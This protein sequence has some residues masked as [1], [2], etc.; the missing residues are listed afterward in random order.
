[1]RLKGHLPNAPNC[2][3]L[4]KRNSWRQ[5]PGTS[6]TR[7]KSIRFSGFN[8]ESRSDLRIGAFD[9]EP[10]AP[11]NKVQPSLEDIKLAEGNLAD[12]ADRVSSKSTEYTQAVTKLRGMR[13]NLMRQNGPENQARVKARQRL[14][15]MVDRF[16]IDDKRDEDWI[17][18][19]LAPIR[20]NLRT[21]DPKQL[22]SYLDNLERLWKVEGQEVQ[23]K[24]GVQEKILGV[25]KK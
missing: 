11:A 3:S 24:K 21:M 2:I 4:T 15:I 14:A 16:H 5:L 8:T 20:E 23:I 7:T 6:G 25:G 22:D 13:D 18:K 12:L 1:M 9:C 17:S 19:T 10:M